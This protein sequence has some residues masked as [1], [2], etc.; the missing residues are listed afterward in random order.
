[1]ATTTSPSSML[2]RRSAGGAVCLLAGVVFGVLSVYSNSRAIC[3]LWVCVAVFSALIS[4]LFIGST[5]RS[6]TMIERR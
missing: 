5:Q 6:C 3:A 2:R 4:G 1:M